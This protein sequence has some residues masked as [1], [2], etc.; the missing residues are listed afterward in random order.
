MKKLL[1]ILLIPFVAY[2]VTE[3]N[4]ITFKDTVRVE[5]VQTN[6]DHLNLETEKELRL[7]DAAG[8]QYMGLKAPSTV[9]S[10]TTLS[11]PDG[12]GSNGQCL[13]TDG[14]LSLEWGNCI[15]SATA[16]TVEA[17]TA[18]F[19]ASTS[20]I[21]KVDTSS[22]DV[23][24]TLPAASGVTDETVVFILTQS[25][26][27]LIIDGNGSETIDGSTDFEL[28]SQYE[29]VELVSDG[30]NW[31]IKSLHLK[32]QKSFTSSATNATTSG[33]EVSLTGNGF[34]LGQGTWEMHPT[35][36]LARTGG[37][38]NATRMRA[39][40]SRTQNTQNNIS[41]ITGL[42]ANYHFSNSAYDILFNS[43]PQ[44]DG[45]FVQGQI[46]RITLTQDSTI[47]L[48]C[49]INAGT[50]ANFRCQTSAYAKRVR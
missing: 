27:D 28:R 35:G 42:T 23:T 8:G 2:A 29:H 37:T 4:S 41:G 18:S 30:S 33:V 43:T 7:Q 9:T 45:F 3:W 13:K 36:E 16:A 40:W 20:Y 17:K 5:G 22:G 6:A 26:N 47:Y 32:E 19:T 25:S 39:N 50:P 1:I 24:A 15:S 44:L 10:S 49:I 31:L 21:Y 14:S 46:V 11:L 12:D 34:T 48:N 38:S